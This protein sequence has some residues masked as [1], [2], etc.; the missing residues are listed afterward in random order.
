MAIRSTATAGSTAALWRASTPDIAARAAVSAAVQDS[1]H[2]SGAG[3]GDA[4]RSWSL[5]TAMSA[6]KL[7]DSTWSGSG[8][9]P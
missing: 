9:C 4:D 8:T 6:V 1:T 7:W 5:N 2:S 3:S